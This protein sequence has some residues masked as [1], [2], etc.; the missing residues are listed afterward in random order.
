MRGRYWLTC[1]RVVDWHFWLTLHKKVSYQIICPKSLSCFVHDCVRICIYWYLW[2]NKH[3]GQCNAS[4]NISTNQARQHLHRYHRMYGSPWLPILEKI[5]KMSFLV[6]IMYNKI[7]F[8]LRFY[9]LE[10]NIYSKKTMSVVQQVL[11]LFSC[12]HHFSH[13]IM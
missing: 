3:A 7:W 13:F 12:N 1:L 5:F 11:Q 8:F 6:C 4:T 10:I 2:L 9:C